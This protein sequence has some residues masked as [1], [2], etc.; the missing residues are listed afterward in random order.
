M[1]NL[2]ILLVV[3]ILVIVIL[4][5]FIAA[6]EKT[7]T[8]ILIIKKCKN[9]NSYVPFFLMLQFLALVAI[10]ICYVN[11]FEFLIVFNIFILEASVLINFMRFKEVFER[12][13]LKLLAVIMAYIL[14]V[15]NDFNYSLR[16]LGFLLMVFLYITNSEKKSV[17]SSNI[18]IEIA[19]NGFEL[20]VLLYVGCKL[21]VATGIN[22]LI[23]Y[24][25]IISLTYV[26]LKK[27]WQEFFSHLEITKQ[28]CCYILLVGLAAYVA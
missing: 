3:F 8:K 10:S 17:K 13:V 14:V 27:I 1:N 11:D 19:R 5:S 12:N 9:L 2:N 24:P 26:V 22:E 25:F 6:P 18:L 20:S 4:S 23:L 7:N 21:I 15:L 16:I 28:T